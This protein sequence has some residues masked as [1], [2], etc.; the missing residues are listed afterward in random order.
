MSIAGMR[1][2]SKIP[3]GRAL[4]AWPPTVFVLIIVAGFLA[5]SAARVI[6]RER[7][8][9]AEEQALEEQ[10][11]ALLEERSRLE[12]A[13]RTFG[14][15]EAIERAA[16]ERLNLKQSGEEVVVVVPPE[17][18]ATPQPPSGARFEKIFG[19]WLAALLRAF[20]R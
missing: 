4:W 3:S 12:A 1:L 17:R 10:V 11:R 18:P 19:P 9:A 15:P 13:I 20:Q 2:F 8:I 7:A 5:T 16:K 14:S 6:I